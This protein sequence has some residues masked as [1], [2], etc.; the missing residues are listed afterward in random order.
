MSLDLNVAGA[1]VIGGAGGGTS[2]G[3]PLIQTVQVSQSTLGAIPVADSVSEAT[4][5]TTADANWNGSGVA[6][7]VSLLKA[8]GNR[9]GI[10]GTVVDGS[11]TIAIGGTAQN[12]FGG[13]VPVNG[14][15]VQNLSTAVLYVNDLGAA[16]SGTVYQI[17]PGI[18][19]STPPNYKPPGAV[20]I[21]GGTSGQAFTARKY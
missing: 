17:N 5:G 4:L 13:L 18:M 14:Y 10:G 2:A 1:K 9:Q 3:D 8:I 15:L 12:L 6:S 16:A 20:S 21:W 7:L 11:G 19:W